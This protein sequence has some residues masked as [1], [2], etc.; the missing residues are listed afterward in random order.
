MVGKVVKK[1]GTTVQAQYMLY[2]AIM[3]SVFLY[4]QESWVVTGSMLKVLEGFYHR[5]ASWILGMT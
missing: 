1:M 3:Q 2:K 5:A 4:E